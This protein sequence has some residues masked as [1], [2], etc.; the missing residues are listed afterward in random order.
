MHR[1]LAVEEALSPAEPED[2]LVPDIGVDAETP[3]VV[4][5]KTHEL[6]WP[7]LLPRTSP[8]GRRNGRP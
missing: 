1:T 2:A 7:D 6:F 8:R 3:P 5:E 4:E